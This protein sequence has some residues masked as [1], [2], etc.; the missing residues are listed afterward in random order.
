MKKLSLTS[1]NA[2]YLLLAVLIISI[3][4]VIFMLKWAN[5]QLEAKS[6]AIAE[7][8]E[9]SAMLE[10]Q[11]EQARL[12]KTELEE[13]GDLTEVVD[14]I[15]PESKSQENVVGE[16]VDIAAKRGLKLE[17][18]AF[19]GSADE[20]NPETSQTEKV[21]ELPGVFALKVET[22]IVTNY[23]N[24]LQFLEDLENNRRQ[25]EVTSLAIEPK[26]DGVNFTASLSISTYIK[27]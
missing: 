15:L 21:K 19:A 9:Q 6:N 5:G 25:F 18:I 2:F 20:K 8:R 16:L 26:E 23:E 10:R 4:A 17:N 14:T 27:P 1:Q 22:Q 3:V 24:V 11:T 12:Y 7:K 13:L